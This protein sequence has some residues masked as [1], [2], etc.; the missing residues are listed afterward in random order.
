MWAVIDPVTKAVI[1]ETQGFSVVKMWASSFAF[2]MLTL[3][4]A[5]RGLWTLPDA[6]F[7]LC[8]LRLQWCRDTGFEPRVLA[9]QWCQ[10]AGFELRVLVI[11]MQLGRGL[12]PLRLGTVLML[13]RGLH[14]LRL[15]IT[16]VSMIILSSGLCSLMTYLWW[17]L[18]SL[19]RLCVYEN[20]YGIKFRSNT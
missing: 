15:G 13:R 3:N 2:W 1:T 9:L 10:D 16:R 18:D 11:T 14:A 8:V 5:R 7:R 12:R 19:Q 6:G 20:S 17:F 4:L